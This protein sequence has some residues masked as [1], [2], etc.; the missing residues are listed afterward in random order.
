MANGN[1]KKNGTNGLK[2]SG[3]GWHGHDGECAGAFCRTG[4]GFHGFFLFRTLLMVIILMVVFMAG[5]RFG[6]LKQFVLGGCHYGGYMMDDRYEMGYPG[7]TV[8]M[9]GMAVPAT[10]SVQ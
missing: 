3:N 10:S 9:G 8:P 6:E 7:A 1:D 5:V 2:N 4:G